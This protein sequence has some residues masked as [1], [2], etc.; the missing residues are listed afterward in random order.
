MR[1]NGNDWNTSSCGEPENPAMRC[2]EGTICKPLLFVGAAD[3]LLDRASQELDNVCV[4][5]VVCLMEW[6]T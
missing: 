2:S 6:S 5:A 3:T 1:D 4:G